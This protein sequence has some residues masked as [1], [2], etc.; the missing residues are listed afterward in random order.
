M[1][2]KV[3]EFMALPGFHDILISIYSS[4][5]TATQRPADTFGV[6]KYEYFGNISSRCEEIDT[7]RDV[8]R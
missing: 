8:E 4:S 3:P 7:G 5:N 1:E 6:L 2:K